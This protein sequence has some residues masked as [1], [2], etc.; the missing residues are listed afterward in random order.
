MGNLVDE[1]ALLGRGVSDLNPQG[2][3]GTNPMLGARVASLDKLGGKI[4]GPPSRAH[5]GVQEVGG[6][7]TMSASMRSMVAWCMEG[8]I[9]GDLF[10]ERDTVNSAGRSRASLGSA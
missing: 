4:V 8:L 2:H 3:M 9:D 10:K 5:G 7:G 1:E 6:L